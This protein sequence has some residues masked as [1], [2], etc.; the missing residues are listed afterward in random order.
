MDIKV[1]TGIGCFDWLLEG[2]FEK[3][4]ITTIYGPAG[5][6]KSNVCLLFAKEMNKGKIIFIDTE[7]SFSVSRFRQICDNVEE[8]M[9][10]IIFLNPTTFEEQKK[11]FKKL[12][13]LVNSKIS[14]IIIDSIAMLYRLE[15][16]KSKNVYEVNRELG[17][18]LGQLTEFARKNNIPVLI[19]NQV[20]ADFEQKGK[21][22]IVGGD[23]LKYQSKC[24]IEIQKEDGLRK[25]I[26]RKHRSIEEGKEVVF[27]ITD[28]GIEE[29][30]LE[31]YK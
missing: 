22:N 4:V 7:G 8:S 17:I 28:L 1:S 14:A 19:T 18:Q 23:L 27:K 9:K 3:G 29:I 13:E 11:A 15:M 31:E 12:N 24:L 25:A 5:S 26:I 2:G 6:G 21:I 30:K 20:Y 10:N 16:G